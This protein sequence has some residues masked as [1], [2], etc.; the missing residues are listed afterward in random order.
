MHA[1]LKV[2]LQLRLMN[3]LKVQDDCVKRNREGTVARERERRAVVEARE[4]AEEEAR[5]L[6]RQERVAYWLQATIYIALGT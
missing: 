5:A 1:P 4:R 3:E 2:D 6:R